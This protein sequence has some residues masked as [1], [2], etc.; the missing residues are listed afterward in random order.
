[1][2]NFFHRCVFKAIEYK[3]QVVAGTNYFIKVHLGGDKYVFIRV[4]QTL[5]H[6]GSKLRLDGFQLDKTEDDEIE[7][8]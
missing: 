4:Y 7:Y 2:R 3:T 8:F 1:M 6:E 5:P